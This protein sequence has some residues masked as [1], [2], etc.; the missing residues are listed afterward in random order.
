MNYGG[1][2]NALVGIAPPQS[3]QNG[4]QVAPQ[5]MA[6]PQRPMM[7]QQPQQAPWR[8]QVPIQ[9]QVQWPNPHQGAYAQ[10]MEQFNPVAR[11]PRSPQRY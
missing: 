6:L 10:W 4:L 11:G 9:P 7:Y 3:V 8:P 5:G 2:R 1:Y